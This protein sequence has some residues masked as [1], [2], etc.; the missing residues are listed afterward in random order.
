[1]KSIILTSFSFV[2]IALLLTN[3]EKEKDTTLTVY[4]RDKQS[5]LVSGAVVDLTADAN[6]NKNINKDLDSMLITPGSGMVQFNLTK[7]YKAGQA[8]VAVMD[9]YAYKIV[10]EDTLIGHSYKKI[11]P[12]QDNVLNVA[13]DVKKVLN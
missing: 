9:I 7:M 5:A 12:Q 2:F 3:C 10:G 11:E 13:I 4:V 8:G 6:G 1:M